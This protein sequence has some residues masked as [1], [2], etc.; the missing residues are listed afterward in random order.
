MYSDEIKNHLE[1]SIS[2]KEKL[3]E[4]AAV[5]EKAAKMLIAAYKNGKKTIAFGNGGSASDAQ[6][7]IGELVGRY[8]IER[9][10]LPGI[11]LSTDTSVLTAIANDYGYDKVF[12]RQIEANANTGDVVFAISTSG[13]SPNV[14]NAI[15]AAKN[16]GCKVIGL[17]G[18]DGGKMAG[19]CDITLIVPSYNTPRIQ[20]A[21]ITIIHI[22]C[23]LLDKELAKNEN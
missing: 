14:I 13:N 9:R 20:E 19:M 4:Q 2:V 8:K 7:I 18:K 15:K 16:A 1:E 21:H 22:L 5:I 10:G 3:K 6:H 23:D 11:A 17:T 12:E